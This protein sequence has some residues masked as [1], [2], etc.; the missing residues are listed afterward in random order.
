MR[1]SVLYP[2]FLTLG[3]IGCGA[4]GGAGGPYNGVA[5]AT[6]DA[7]DT[8]DSK[9]AADVDAGSQAGPDVSC[10]GIAILPQAKQFDSECA[11]L[12]TCPTSGQCYCGSKCAEDKAPHCD[13]SICADNNPK[14]FCGEKCSGDK[15]KCPQFIC[16]PLDVKECE[17]QDD[18]VFNNA[19]P[20]SSCSCTPMPDREPDC[21]CGTCTP[22]KPACDA[23]K[24]QGKNPTKCIVVPGEP[25]K[26]CYCK[27]C[28]LLGNDARCFEL[29]CA[30][31]T[32]P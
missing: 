11:F 26:Q 28:G 19:K 2:L 3:V 4:G 14:C 22:V 12:S 24:C 7:T 25:H 21:W 9:G 18:C 17:A 6:T 20:P 13:Q 1:A 8:V 30:D 16:G 31:S 32:D 5:V 27:T 23:G 10:I 15:K 29:A